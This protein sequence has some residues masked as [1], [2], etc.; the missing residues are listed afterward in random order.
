MTLHPCFVGC[1]VSK[2]H[3]DIFDPLSGEE[4][5]IANTE[6]AIG[7][8]VSA[9]KSDRLHITF[10]ATGRHDRRLRQALDKAGIGYARVNPQ[11]ARQFG[12]ALGYMAK[13]DRLDAKL[14]A[15]MGRMMKPA[16]DEPADAEREELAQMHKRRDQLVAMRQNE[17]LRLNEATEWEGATL[18]RHI[19]WLDA[20]IAAVEEEC[21]RYLR[22]KPCLART[23]RL[24]RSI[25]GVGPVTSLTLIA[26]MPELGRCR[27]QTAA[28]LAGLAPF[29]ADSGKFQG[30]RRIRGGRKRVRDA[31]Y[32][33]AVT[34]AR[35]SSR[36]KTFATSLRERGKPFKVATIALARKILVIANAV[37]RDQKPYAP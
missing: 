2:H 21:R 36:L 5:R 27:P 11:R 22:S 35:S 3:L 26:M 8:W 7:A 25:P 24:L 37:I 32:M 34:A 20:E 9:R 12:K 15:A 1:D 4:R 19:A 33:A 17:K 30:Q 28:A 29:N 13:T 6:T 18:Q 14:L 16:A 10:E 31:L 23:D